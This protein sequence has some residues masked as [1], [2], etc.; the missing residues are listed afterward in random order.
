MKK[1]NIIKSVWIMTILVIS[2]SAFAAISPAQVSLTAE[3]EQL[4][5]HYSKMMADLREEITQLE[6][7]VDEK[8]KAEFTKQLSALDNVTPV[9]KTV[10]GNEIS[11][12]YGPGNPAFAEKQKEVLSAARAVMKD[13]DAF[14]ESMQNGTENFIL[15]DEGDIDKLLGIEITQID[16]KQFKNLKRLSRING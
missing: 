16:D 14:I 7:K 12:K 8:K 6:P 13:I 9:T 2:I 1:R 11:V 10:M 3:G 5:A 15:T 4:K